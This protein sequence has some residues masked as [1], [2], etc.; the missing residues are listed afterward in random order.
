MFKSRKEKFAYVQ[1]LKKGRR[2]GAL[3]PSKRK[4]GKVKKHG[5]K[6]RRRNTSEV[7]WGNYRSNDFVY[8]S[9]GRISG[10]YTADGFFEPD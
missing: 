6:K 3:F 7:S 10:S 5:C 8:N 1:G 4:A 2:R 9:N